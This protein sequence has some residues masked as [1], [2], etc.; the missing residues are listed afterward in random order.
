MV[1]RVVRWVG[2]LV[3]QSGSRLFVGLVGELFVWLVGGL[4]F[5]W[6]VGWWVDWS[7]GWLVGDWVCWW[8]GWLTG[9]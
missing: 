3:R 9:G 8:V 7:V 6:F 1:G 2:I 4:G 5:V